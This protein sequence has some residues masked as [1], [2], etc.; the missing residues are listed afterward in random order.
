MADINNLTTNAT[1]NAK[2]RSITNLTTTAAVKAEINDVKN[3]I[4]SHSKYITNP[5]FN[6][7]TVEDF[8]ARLA[9]TNLASKNDIANFVKKTNFDNKLKNLNKK[10]T[11][12][13]TKHVLVE[14]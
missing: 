7:L 2:I 4:P 6:K 5:E 1:L 12:N 3:K 11:S 10:F 13:K 8:A 14:N 9:E